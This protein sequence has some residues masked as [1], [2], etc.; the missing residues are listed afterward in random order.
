MSLEQRKEQKYKTGTTEKINVHS[1]LYT[2]EESYLTETDLMEL[3]GCTFSK[4]V[5]LLEHS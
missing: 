2:E 5:N 3:V 1:C 4:T